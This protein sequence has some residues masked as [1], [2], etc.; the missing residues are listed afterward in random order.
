MSAFGAFWPQLNNVIKDRMTAIEFSS[1]NLFINS[2]PFEREKY[3]EN[4]STHKYMLCPLGNGMQSPKIIE[5]ILNCC[6]PVMTDNITSRNL[7]KKGFPILIVNE[8]TEITEK[9]LNENYN[10]FETEIRVF[11]EKVKDLDKW[12]NFSFN[13]EK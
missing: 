6:I 5:A 13:L 1:K 7:I 11:K 10:R 8:W 3:F 4:L 2:G 12:W 9:K